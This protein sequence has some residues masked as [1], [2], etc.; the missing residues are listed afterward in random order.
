MKYA[1]RV[2][3]PPVPGSKEGEG[4]TGVLSEGEREREGSEEG[5]NGDGDGDGAR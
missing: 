2:L 1:C 4:A 5:D 3:E